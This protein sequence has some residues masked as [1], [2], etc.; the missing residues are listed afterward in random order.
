MTRPD[1]SES[2]ILRSF[3][4]TDRL[5][6]AE[7][8]ARPGPFE[9][10]LGAGDGSFLIAYATAH[11]EVNLLGVER[12]LGRLRKID[13]KAHRGNLTNVR[14]I[15]MEANYL[16]RYLLPRASI[17]AFHIYF[18]DPWPKRRHW[19][20]RL[21]TEPFSELLRGALEPNGVVYLR[22]DD[23]LYFAQMTEVFGK[24][25]NFTRIETPPELLTIVTDFEREFHRRGVA[26]NHAA[27]EKSK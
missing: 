19:K 15:R 5:P 14:G 17:R 24:N 11:P 13:R 25:E 21:I 1:P 16:V 7:I 10:E 27:Y 22:T 20:N 12:L 26:T 9:V 6:L 18:P 23:K 8:F 3:S 4:I 2:F